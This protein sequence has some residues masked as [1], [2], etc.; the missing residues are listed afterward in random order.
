MRTPIIAG[1]W[2]MNTTVHE[3]TGLA[4]G[5]RDGLRMSSGVEIVLCPPFIA[6]QPVRDAVQG[7]PIKVGAQNMHFEDSGAYTGEVGPLMLQG[8]CEY[9][10]LGHS[11]RR[12]LFSDYFLTFQMS[13]SRTI[14]RTCRNSDFRTIFGL[15]D[16]SDFSSGPA[17]VR[18]RGPSP[19]RKSLRL[20]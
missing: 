10:V 3:A 1:N 17:W 4:T 2:K 5:V 19:G 7:S 12:Q 13:D 18:P 11:E 6:L 20:F 14:F 9:V 15:S 16:F 8:L